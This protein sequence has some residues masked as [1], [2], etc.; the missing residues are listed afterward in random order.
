MHKLLSVSYLGANPSK[1]RSCT[2]GARCPKCAPTSSPEPRIMPSSKTD[3][4]F[5][6]VQVGSDTRR[7]PP[8]FRFRPRERKP[9][10]WR[11]TATIQCDGKGRYE[12]LF[13]TMEDEKCGMKRCIRQHEKSHVRDFEAKWPDGCKDKE[14]GYVPK[15]GPLD[16]PRMTTEEFNAFAKESECRAHTI[17]LLCA[18]SVKPSK[19]CEETVR[20]Y[21]EAIEIGKEEACSGAP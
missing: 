5:S 11:N 2:C 7:E 20:S 17:H 15:G 21:I 4:A 3:H 10:D 16:T 8:A 1:A 19:D 18:Q 12:I 13:G 6:Q 14:R 9:G